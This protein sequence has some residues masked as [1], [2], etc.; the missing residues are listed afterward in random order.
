MD[1]CSV[2]TTGGVMTSTGVVEQSK[3]TSNISVRKGQVL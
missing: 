1:I 3:R 2:Y